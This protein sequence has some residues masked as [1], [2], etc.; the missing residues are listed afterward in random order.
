MEPDLFP[1]L[2]GF[3]EA[4]AVEQ[5]DAMIEQLRVLVA[6]WGVILRG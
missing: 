2:V 3:K 1:G 4:P 5:R 6:P